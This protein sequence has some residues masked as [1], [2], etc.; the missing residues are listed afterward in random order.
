MDPDFEVILT[1][2]TSTGYQVAKKNYSDLVREIYHFPIDF[3][4]FSKRAW[5][6]IQPDIC[7][8]TEGELWPEH[9]HRAKKNQVPVM[10]INARMSDK[11]FEYYKMLGQ[12]SRKFFSTLDVVVASSEGNADRFK[13]LGVKNEKLR[14]SGNLK[15]DTAIPESLSKEQRLELAREMGLPRIDGKESEAL[16]LCGASTWPGEEQILLK[17][18][19]ELR[20]EDIRL[21]LLL[22]P[23]H[24]ERRKDIR[25]ELSNFPFSYHFRS[26]GPATKEVDIS[27]GDTTGELSN[28]IQLADIVFVGKSLAPHT[29]G[30][31]PIEA[32]ML[33]KPILFGPG[34]SNFRDIARSLLR[35]GVAERIVDETSLKEAI[36]TLSQNKTLRI[37]RGEQADEWLKANQGATDRTLQAI[38]SLI[39]STERC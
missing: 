30:Q 24:M 6:I 23:R 39:Q 31:T 20:Q 34:M 16:I 14:V 28:F 8:L 11:T 10:L 1:T 37:E 12:L 38:K 22:T 35:F 4:I 36:R 32:G 2:T 7:I 3:F 5:K 17:I 29:Q 15:C 26:D 18:C 21:F 33:K 13:F 19:Q 25:A 27:I 9:I